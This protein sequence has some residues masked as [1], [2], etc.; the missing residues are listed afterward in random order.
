MSFTSSI[1]IIRT[2]ISSYCDHIARRNLSGRPGG[3]ELKSELIKRH[4]TWKSSSVSSK[5]L[6]G[7]GDIRCTCTLLSVNLKPLFGT[8]RKVIHMYIFMSH[9]PRSGK[10][11][12]SIWAFGKKRYFDASN[13]FFCYFWMRSEM[14]DFLKRASDRRW[15]S[16]Y[17]GRD[18]YTHH[19]MIWKS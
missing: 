16:W 19:F 14:M 6:D 15:R 8:I 5:I 7:I 2:A 18:V 17:H 12:W 13:G 9:Y 3:R 4:N 1:S 11:S 10:W